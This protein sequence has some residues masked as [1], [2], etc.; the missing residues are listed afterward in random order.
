M[1]RIGII[2]F[3]N[4]GSAL[5]AGL[6]GGRYHIGISEVKA[7]RAK[8]ASQEYGLRVYKSKNEL[9]SDSDILVLAVK[10]QE[11][12][13]LLEETGALP[14]EKRVISI[15]A[16]RSMDSIMKR[17]NIGGMARFMPNLAA[18][19]AKALVGI[20]FS[21]DSEEGFRKN[22]LEIASA[23]GRPMEVPESLIAAITG[24]SGSGIA[25]VFSFFHAMALGGV[26]AG[27]PYPQALEAT[28]QTVEGALEV[29]RKSGENP[30]EWLN[31]VISPAGTTI[32]G[33]T[34]LE[35]NSFTYGVI[36]AVEAASERAKELE[37]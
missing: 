20:A 37:S 35:E 27:L 2:G 31:R 15:I 23:I 29:V 28:L 25:Y 6:K 34:A 19:E 21:P 3:G 18:R 11:L 5:A 13:H 1:N 8:I 33:I 17:L 16:G 9:V 7:D 30:M 12:E 32:A 14:P 24:L 10:P 26:K 22:C 36:R 4:M